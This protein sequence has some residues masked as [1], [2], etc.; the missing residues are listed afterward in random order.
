MS[1]NQLQS[2]CSCRKEKKNFLYVAG[3]TVTINIRGSLEKLEHCQKCCRKDKWTIK[4]FFSECENN[5]DCL[6][7]LFRLSRIQ[8]KSQQEIS[9]TKNKVCLYN[10]FNMFSAGIIIAPN[11]LTNAQPNNNIK[12]CLWNHV[13]FLTIKYIIII[14]KIFIFHDD[15]QQYQN[16]SEAITPKHDYEPT[17]QKQVSKKEIVKRTTN[18]FYPQKETKP[19]TKPKKDIVVDRKEPAEEAVKLKKVLSNLE[20]DDTIVKYKKDSIDHKKKVIETPTKQERSKNEQEDEDKDAILRKYHYLMVDNAISCKVP[21]QEKLVK[22][23]SDM[24]QIVDKSSKLSMK[25]RDNC[26]PYGKKD[27]QEAEHSFLYDEDSLYAK[28]DNVS[29]EDKNERRFS[30]GKYKI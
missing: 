27:K 15:Q 25:S 11:V 24:I 18:E 14:N 8:E 6:I 22:N 29:Q 13:F 2:S 20:Q 17:H 4:E 28:D 19:V 26:D 30:H 12:L 5:P 1:P 10:I 9:F 23:S 21:S 3:D 16:I 7:D